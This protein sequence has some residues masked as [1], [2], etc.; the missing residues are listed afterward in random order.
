MHWWTVSTA[1]PLSL[2][3]EKVR[4]VTLKTKL[5]RTISR[6]HC[7]A[8]LIAILIALWCK[9]VLRKKK[10]EDDDDEEEEEVFTFYFRLPIC[11]FM[12]CLHN[13]NKTSFSGSQSPKTL[14]PK[15]KPGG[16][17]LKTTFKLFVAGYKCER[18]TCCTVILSILEPSSDMLTLHVI[19]YCFTLEISVRPCFCVLEVS[20]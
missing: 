6:E 3:C 8:V 17:H 9:A 14:K 15:V 5:K 11:W 20:V 19:N 16:Y 7:M 4:A 13:T 18:S 10:K 1:C 2:P 12:I